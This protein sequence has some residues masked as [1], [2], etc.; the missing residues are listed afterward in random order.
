MWKILINISI[1]FSIFIS[2]INAQ[3]KDKKADLDLIL[4]KLPSII[5]AEMEENE[6]PSL[7]IAIVHD[8]DIVFNQAFGYADLDDKRS[9]TTGTIY[10]IGSVTKV[11]TALMLVQMYEN[12]IV[13]LDMPVKKYLPEYKVISPFP[14]TQPT[15]L[16]QLATH[17]SGLPRETSVGFYK[18]IHIMKWALTRGESKMHQL[19]SI[20]EVLSSLDKIEFDSHPNSTFGYYSNVGYIVLGVALERA[21]NQTYQE[22]ME[23]N[24]FEPLNMKNTSFN[25]SDEQMKR[26][27][28]GYAKIEKD[29]PHFKVPHMEANSYIYAGGLYS[30]AE[31]L[32][33]FI[34][35]QFSEKPLGDSQ[36][37]SADGLRMMRRDY[38]AW[39]FEW[40][41]YHP[42]FIAGGTFFGHQAIIK[43]IPRLKLGIV[44]LKNVYTPLEFGN[45][46]ITVMN[47]ILNELKAIYKKPSLKF[48]PKNINLHRYV[49]TYILPGS[50]AIANLSIN[51]KKLVLTFAEDIDFDFPPLRPVGV[52]QFCFEDEP[53]DTDPTITFEENE[54]GYIYR[55]K[56]M[57][58]YFKKMVD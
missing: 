49:G 1:S 37:I 3:T 9:A 43:I 12:G 36:I 30:T 57:N 26:C 8:Q 24:I 10:R 55:F 51:N 22:Y 41:P 48:N 15:T 50:S 58:S 44:I 45:P 25:L 17:T 16:K 5:E 11:F 40:D 32:A 19:P 34:S 47:S 53:P 14:D 46:S 20:D 54:K 27:A 28:T 21:V 52:H 29:T 42:A 23:K 31:D 38:F 56:I 18:Q 33:H 2:S 39:D 35:L 7:S 6:F 4:S 13:S